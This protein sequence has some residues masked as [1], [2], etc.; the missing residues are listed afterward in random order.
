VS[1]GPTINGSLGYFRRNFLQFV[2]V[3]FQVII[4]VLGVEVRTIL[5]DHEQRIDTV[6][7]DKADAAQVPP[8]WFRERVDR[9]EARIDAMED[10][11]RRRINLKEGR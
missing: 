8:D 5:K 3:V 7:R 1:N 4:T 6:E 2:I 11:E 9:N 10:R